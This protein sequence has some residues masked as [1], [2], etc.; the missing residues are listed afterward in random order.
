MAVADAEASSSYFFYGITSVSLRFG[1]RVESR[2]C[3]MYAGSDCHREGLVGGVALEKVVLA[4]G[5]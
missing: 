2:A 4:L 3:R 1:I 5:H